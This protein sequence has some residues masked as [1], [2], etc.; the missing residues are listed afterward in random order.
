MN[1]THVIERAFEIAERDH[2]CLKVS[3]VREALTWEGW[4][5]REQLRRRIKAR[6]ARAVRRFELAESRP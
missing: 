6:G 4:S 3:D 1:Q 5:I 2:A